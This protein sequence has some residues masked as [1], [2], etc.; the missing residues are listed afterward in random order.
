MFKFAG[1]IGN[2]FKQAKLRLWIEYIVIGAVV[3]LISFSSL[4]WISS[5]RDEDKILVVIPHLPPY[6]TIKK[7]GQ[8]ILIITNALKHYDNQT[9]IEF[10]LQPFSRHWSFYLS[11][12]RVDAVA[13]VPSSVELEGYPSDCYITYQNGIG[14][15]ASTFPT[16][17][18][19]TDIEKLEGYRVVGFTGAKSIIPEVGQH[20][21]RF[22]VYIE[23]E[24]QRLHSKLLSQNMVDAVIADRE[25]IEY[26]NDQLDQADQ[27]PDYRFDA[28]FE[29]TPYRMIFR[30]VEI[31]DK[32][33]QA[34]KEL[35]THNLVDCSG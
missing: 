16:R 14:Y 1:F 18:L 7:Q 6:A 19:K 22:K 5:D 12:Q 3:L 4:P 28:I 13:T 23:R 27:I 30:S 25:I 17:F 8:E 35:K 15:R 21:E 32:F 10:V 33:N 29:P 11:D 2:S 31:R 20:L 26:Y 34:L 24:N 9:K